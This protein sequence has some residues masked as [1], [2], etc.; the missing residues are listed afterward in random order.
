MHRRDS[1]WIITPNPEELRAG[2][3]VTEGDGDARNASADEEI[4]IA[5]LFPERI[6]DVFSD[7]KPSGSKVTLRPRSVARAEQ[8]APGVALLKPR[9]DAFAEHLRRAHSSIRKAC[10]Q[11]DLDSEK[12]RTAA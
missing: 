8:A 6:S 9:W 10:V 7:P 1:Y 4:P 3:E 5:D 12:E 2:A 11:C